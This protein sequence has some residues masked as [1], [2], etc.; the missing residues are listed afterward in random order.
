MEFRIP[1]ITKCG[2]T[3][4]GNTCFMNS[5][6][7][8]MIHNKLL[9]LFFIKTNNND[10]DDLFSGKFKE[11][12]EFSSDGNSMHEFFIPEA[13]KQRL[14]DEIRAK[15]NLGKDDE[16]SIDIRDYNNFI[17]HSLSKTFSEEI[18]NP[19]VYRGNSNIEP[20]NF[21]NA[22][23]RKRKCFLGTEQ[24]DA[25]EA[26][27]LIL[28]EIIEETGL[29]SNP[30]INNPPKLYIEYVKRMK[31]FKL[32]VANSE[33]DEE[34]SV[35][36]STLKQFKLDN[37]EIL[38]Q[39]N[40][41]NH[42]VN[43][44]KRRHNLMIEK[45]RNFMVNERICKNCNNSSFDFDSTNILNIPMH[46]TTLLEC[47]DAFTT[48]ELSDYK[49]K[50]CNKKSNA[51]TVTKITSSSSVLYISL[52]RFKKNHRRIEKIETNIEI[53]HNINIE[54]YCDFIN[55]K[56]TCDYRLRGIINHYGSYGGGHYTAYCRDL[57]D[58]ESW[59]EFN[60][61]RANLIKDFEIDGRSA[62]IL[63]YESI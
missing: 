27:T 30:Q 43:L 60:D 10:S 41:I 21:K 32:M 2:L 11:E 44:H 9:F 16:V 29:E 28:D 24:Q 37:P 3:N 52:E 49:C 47:F 50:Y 6:L 62:Y 36:L 23:G 35:I 33:T 39:Y 5:T 56:T 40:H 42:M 45:M 18:L 22:L 46:G 34:K 19:I 25:Q 26:L 20:R 15:N 55:N 63:L 57:I 14:G 58:N 59:Y 54:K 17:N 38:K 53:P 13:A 51:T 61:S 1:K 8:L 48:G 12:L 7:Q 31:E 4:I